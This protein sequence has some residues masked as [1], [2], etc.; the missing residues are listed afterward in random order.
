ML[1]WKKLI[2]VA[3]KYKDIPVNVWYDSFRTL[4]INGM[5]AVLVVIV[6]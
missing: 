3:S 2:T 6:W 1:T 5:G 4:H